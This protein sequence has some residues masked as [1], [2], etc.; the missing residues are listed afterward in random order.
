[1][2]IFITR[3]FGCIIFILFG[4]SA[5]SQTIPSANPNPNSF[6]YETNAAYRILSE[7][8]IPVSIGLPVFSLAKGF[9]TKNKELQIEGAK[10]LGAL[11]IN[12]V[13]TDFV[14]YSVYKNRNI[15]TGFFANPTGPET[16]TSLPSRHGTAAFANAAT[17]SINHPKWYV[18]IPSYLWASSV[19]YSRTQMGENY[20]TNLA[21]SIIIGVGSAYLN[22]FL[23]KALFEK[24]RKQKIMNNYLLLK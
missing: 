2:K 21:G 5:I 20:T 12:E 17:F 23:F 11:I 19:V 9:A 15:T 7:S 1:M 16:I 10:Y 24:K 14:K 4:F 13:I 8:V 22:H 18:V 3:Y 6:L